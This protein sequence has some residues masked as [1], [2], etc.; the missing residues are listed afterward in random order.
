MNPPQLGQPGVYDLRDYEVSSSFDSVQTSKFQRAIDDVARKR[1]I[2]YVPPGIYR[3][4]QLK[5]KSNLTLYLAPGTII[6]GTGKVSD[7]PR[8]KLGTQ[9]IYL[10]DC[11]DVRLR[12]RGVIDGQGRALRLST[13][14]ADNSR[15][16]LI[17]SFRATDCIVEDVILR[18]AGTWAI[19]LVESSDLRFS[20]YKLISNTILDDPTFPWEPNTDGFDPDNSSHVI[21]ENGF[22]S[23]SDDAIAV[24]LKH[25]KL[26]DMD[27][28]QFRNNVVWTVKS[29]LKIGTEVYDHKMTNI[30]FENNEV[31]HADRGISVYCYRGATI[32]NPKWINNYFEFIGGNIKRMNMEIKI[33]DDEGK[34][35]LNDVLIKDNTFECFSQN[36][37]RLR[38]LDST[39]VINGVTFDNLVI[40]GKRR[41]S[42]ADA[43]ITD[44]NSHLKN[45]SFK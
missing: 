27:D 28:I 36:P 7:Y 11:E 4:G 41:T 37:S 6:K 38:G 20:N 14:N 40:A 32:E 8:G 9:Q 10:L 19:H 25:G 17:R 16:K 33:K 42:L 22:V 31:V 34:G 3:S 39:H 21:I 35:Y 26:D 45:V 43:Q 18:D 29:A 23:C 44:N 5:M 13:D 1:G 15:L 2:L 12:G 30:V 24:K